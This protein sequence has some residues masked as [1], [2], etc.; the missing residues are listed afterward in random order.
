MR[1]QQP[2]D[3]AAAKEKALR[4]LE[5][6]A[7]SEYELRMK[8]RR[9]GAL[10]EDIDEIVEFLLEY[11]LL[12]DHAYAERLAADMSSLKKYGRQRIRAELSHRGIQRSIIDDVLDNLECDEEE[13]LLPL[14][15]KKLCGDFDR[16]SRDRAF[17]YFA[18][19]GYKFDDI[20]RAFDA[21]AAE[22]EEYE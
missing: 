9:A 6:R 14:M 21:A 15:K 16:K 3:K 17:R 10:A 19:R 22:Y 4:I 2:L 13:M 18:A 12:D 5:F 1:E 8:L 11:R 7:N 20:R